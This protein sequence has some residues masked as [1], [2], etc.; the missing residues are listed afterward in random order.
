MGETIDSGILYFLRE[1]IDLGGATVIHNQR[2]RK[3][4]IDRGWAISG[5]EPYLLCI[6]AAGRAILDG[7]GE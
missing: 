2:S 7:K 1:M 6:T 3:L 4:L 5:D